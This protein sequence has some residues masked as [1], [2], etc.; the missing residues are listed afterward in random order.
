MFTLPS[1]GT[2]HKA[3]RNSNR[4]A[5]RPVSQRIHRKSWAPPDLLEQ[6]SDSDKIMHY[7]QQDYVI[8]ESSQVMLQRIAHRLNNGPNPAQILPELDTS[9]LE[10]EMAKLSRQKSAAAEL[11]DGKIWPSAAV[12]LDAGH[13][14]YLNQPANRSQAE[15]PSRTEDTEH[16][17]V[18]VSRPVRKWEGGFF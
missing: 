6:S 16:A 11:D 5:G 8:G 1:I 10:L 4:W 15:T 3:T 13:A 7:S 2:R 17:S 9:D 14:V 18:T 12:E